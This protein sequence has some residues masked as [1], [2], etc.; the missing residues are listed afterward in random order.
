M[1]GLTCPASSPTC[2][3]HGLTSSSATWINSEEASGG[4]H[5]DRIRS[6]ELYRRQLQ[7]P[8]IVTFDEL[9]DLDR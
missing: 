6:F 9:L 2:C 7:D 3:D 8:E 4:H 5:R 1:T